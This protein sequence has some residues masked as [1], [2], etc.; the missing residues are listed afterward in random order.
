M[1]VTYKTRTLP[2]QRRLVPNLLRSILRQLEEARRP[3]SDTELIAAL[4]ITYRRTDPEFQRQVRLNLRDGVAYGI[5]KRQKDHFSL[6]SRR[7]GE[8]MAQLDPPSSHR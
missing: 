5:L 1:P 3:M 2:A 4:G 8:L 7:L 6:R